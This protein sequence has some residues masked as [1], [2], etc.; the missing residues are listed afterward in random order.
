[1]VRAV[2]MSSAHW[3]SVLWHWERCIVLLIATCN[4]NY[5]NKCIGNLVRW[6]KRSQPEIACFG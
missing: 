1:M 5:M 2:R 4:I 6:R 3:R